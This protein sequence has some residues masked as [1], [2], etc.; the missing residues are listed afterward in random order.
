MK[1]SYSLLISIFLPFLLTGIAFF[2]IYYNENL[3]TSLLLPS[4]LTMHTYIYMILWALQYFLLGYASY[5]IYLHYVKD[6]IIVYGIYLLLFL[7]WPITLFIFHQ[8]FLTVILLFLSWGLSIIMIY[9]F[10]KMKPLAGYLLIPH[11]LWISY[12]LYY[13]FQI[14]IL[15]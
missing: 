2:T 9:T 10:Y 6:T 15:N 14:F 13:H 3:Y 5:N 12:M 1:R 8:Y 11:F 7:V 4:N